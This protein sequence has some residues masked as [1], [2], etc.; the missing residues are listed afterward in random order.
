MFLW[1]FFWKYF[2]WLLRTSLK[3]DATLKTVS[4]LCLR[5]RSPS[6]H[7]F[8][9][10]DRVSTT[11]EIIQDWQLGKSGLPRVRCS[12]IPHSVT[13]TSRLLCHAF[14]MNISISAKTLS[15]YRD[16]LL[17]SKKHVGDKNKENIQSTIKINQDQIN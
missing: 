5:P 11:M 6:K 16:I 14:F 4:D 17:L 9:S 8:S 13:N 7:V 10:G 1:T 15:F 3:F 12:V 2:D